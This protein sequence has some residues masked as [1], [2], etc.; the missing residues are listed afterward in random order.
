MYSDHNINKNTTADI[1]K[2]A[3]ECCPDLSLSHKGIADL[4]VVGNVVGIRP[5]RKGG[6]RVQNEY[7][8]KF[9]FFY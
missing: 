4:K 8:S 7:F 3:I 1:L 6:P 9:F 5:T 2:R